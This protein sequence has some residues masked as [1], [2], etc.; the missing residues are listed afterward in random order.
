MVD[1]DHDRIKSC[2]R[3]EISDEVNGELP[4]GERDVR[5][6]REQRRHNRVGVSLVLLTDRTAVMRVA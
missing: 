5:L 3:R 6:D 1:H 2:R 4:K